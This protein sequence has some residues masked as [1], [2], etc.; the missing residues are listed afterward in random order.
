MFSYLV[1]GLQLGCINCCVVVVGNAKHHEAPGHAVDTSQARR[2]RQIN[3][4]VLP[5]RFFILQG[6]PC[7]TRRP[8]Q[9][10]SVQLAW[11]N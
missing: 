11:W 6:V 9:C 3:E 2:Q 7:R 10:F 4:G 1:D 5:V 8:L